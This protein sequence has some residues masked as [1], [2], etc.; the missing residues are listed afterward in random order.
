MSNK[1]GKR[2]SVSI[3][4]GIFFGTPPYSFG[5]QYNL[6][7]ISFGAPSYCLGTYQKNMN[8]VGMALINY[9]SRRGPDSRGILFSRARKARIHTFLG[10]RRIIFL[11]YVHISFGTYQKKVSHKAA[12]NRKYQRNFRPF[13]DDS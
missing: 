5:T 11:W 3:R 6:R 9:Y 8:R 4:A 2:H 7:Y 12:A 13:L 1:V 10:L